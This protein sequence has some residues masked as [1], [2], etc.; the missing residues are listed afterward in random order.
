VRV[1]AD[2]QALVWYLA[3]PSRLSD[4]ALSALDD[5]ESSDGIDVC[6]LTLAELWVATHKRSASRR[7][8]LGAFEL[9]KATL[10]DPDL[11]FDIV[12]ITAATASYFEAVA[13]PALRD[14]FDRFIVAT[15]LE[16]R[17]PL[18]SADRAIRETAGVAVVW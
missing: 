3:E 14:P 1:V 2:S 12:P 11:N 15:S 10:A 5:A 7:L 16:L 6:V 18:V 9:V 8:E 4:A 13:W 17:L